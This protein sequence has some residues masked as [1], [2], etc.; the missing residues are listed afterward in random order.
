LDLRG[1]FVH[2]FGVRFFILWNR[3][4]AGHVTT[5]QLAAY[6]ASLIPVLAI[7]NAISLLG[8]NTYLAR[9]S[10]FDKINELFA[11]T[12]ALVSSNLDRWQAHPRDSKFARR[13]FYRW[14]GGRAAIDSVTLVSPGE[15][16]F[17]TR[18]YWD[19]V[20]FYGSDSYNSKHNRNIRTFLSF[21]EL[22]LCSIF[23][24]RIVLRLRREHVARVPVVGGSLGAKS[25]LEELKKSEGVLEAPLSNLDYTLSIRLI[26]LAEQSFHYMN[27]EF[28]AHKEELSWEEYR[29]LRFLGIFVEYLIWF[30]Y[31]EAKF[32]V[33]RISNLI[34]W[35]QLRGRTFDGD[36][37]NRRFQ[38]FGKV[39][40]EIFDL[41]DTIIPRRAIAEKIIQIRLGSLAPI[42][43]TA[44]SL[45]G[46]AV[47][48]PMTLVLGIDSYARLAEVAVYSLACTAMAENF[49]FGL[50]LLIPWKL[51]RQHSVIP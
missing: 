6:S 39:R 31:F 8:A 5:T 27:D 46:Y 9:Y 40:S 4:Q 18:P 19:G 34:T 28:R 3:I 29:K 12:S 26:L 33:L 48:Q 7:T 49:L 21:H 38:N 16:L 17:T 15:I 2:S 11:Q 32:L 13:S 25:F 43:L 36:A 47:V 10:A 45:F 50:W 23:L 51:T 30:N 41:R 37:L 42:I 14:L 35:L 20:W 22:L 44:L 1:Y 24:L